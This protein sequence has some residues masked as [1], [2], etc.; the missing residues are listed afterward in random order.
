MRGWEAW[1]VLVLESH[2]VMVQI[3]TYIH[4]VALVN[5]PRLSC[6]P[7]CICYN[8]FVGR[9]I[10]MFAIAEENLARGVT[11][12]LYCIISFQS[13]KRDV[14]SKLCGPC[15]SFQNLLYSVPYS[16]DS[17]NSSFNKNI[18]HF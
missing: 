13:H 16:I 5:I 4:L 6:E 1:Q 2:Y 15:I 8:S 18:P 11:R 9:V 3:Y 7:M 12:W 17:L 14:M 10:G